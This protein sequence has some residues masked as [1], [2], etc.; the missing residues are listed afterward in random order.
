M[1]KL[2]TV[3]LL[4]L[5]LFI[6]S[7]NRARSQF[8]M[9]MLDTTKELGR[10]NRDLLS[11]FDHIRIS[12]YMQP[13]YQ[14]ASAKGAKTF[15]GGDFAPNVDNRFMLRR[16]R[17][18]FEYAR[19][20]KQQRNQV[21]FVFQFDGTERGVFI[22]DFW[23]RVWENK[24]E[25][26]AFTTGMFARPFGYEV[27]YSSGVREA[28]E[29]GRMSQ[30]LMKTERDLGFMVTAESKKSGSFASNFKLDAGIFNGQGL[31]APNEYDSYKDFI[32]QIVW[33]PTKIADKLYASGGLSLLE[34]G[35]AQITNVTYR[36]DDKA[37]KKDFIADST[38]THVNAK[39]PRKYYG[40]NLQLKYLTGWGSSELRGE[41]WQGT[42]TAYQSTSETPGSQ[43]LDNTGKNLPMYIRQFSGGFITFLQNIVSKKHQVGIKYD[44]YDPNTE[45]AGKTIGSGNSFNQADIKYGT[46]GFGYIH[47][48]SENFKISFWYDL[49]KNEHTSYAG[50]EKDLDD[51]VLTVRLQFTF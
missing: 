15:S 41:Y 28:P 25:L 33:K 21:Q 37:G 40:A 18:R 9:D 39:L 50:Y 8:L 36:I 48:M 32:G 10:S 45:F 47:Y 13:Q 6:F 38:T 29:R 11:R 19:T 16:G 34:G 4:I 5:G 7:G 27:N 1:L 35:I 30:T 49:V 51:D 24:F 46:I 17:I 20:D 44:W 2:L 26:F 23:G 3:R 42:Q 31:T 22:R 43:P 14:V 12:G